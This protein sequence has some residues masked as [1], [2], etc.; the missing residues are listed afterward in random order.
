MKNHLVILCMGI[1]ALVAGG[2]GF[3]GG[4]YYFSSEA[5][6]G[7]NTTAAGNFRTAVAVFREDYAGKR[8]ILFG[9]DGRREQFTI[10]DHHFHVVPAAV[11]LDGKPNHDFNG[12]M[13]NSAAHLNGLVVMLAC[14]WME[15]RNPAGKE[16]LAKLR[17]HMPNFR[18]SA[19]DIPPVKVT[20]LEGSPEMI[21]SEA[22]QW[23]WRM[24]KDPQ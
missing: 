4:G 20:D 18:V 21:R 2:L 9:E 6:Q 7:E 13:A 22:S 16:L 17:D 14:K 1:A 12:G 23:E 19:P 15:D 3:L 8:M 24:E 10:G 11:T 5:D